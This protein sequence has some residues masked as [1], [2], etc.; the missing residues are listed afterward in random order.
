MG[1]GWQAA[2]DRDYSWLGEVITKRY[3]GDDRELP[4]LAAGVLQA[5]AGI[6]VEDFEAQADQFL[7]NTH[8]PT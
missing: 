4:V 3:L 2:Y 5:F 7:R 6:T 1:D 8:H